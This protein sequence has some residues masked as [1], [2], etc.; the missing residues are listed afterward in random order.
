MGIIAPQPR[1][2]DKHS[3]RLESMPAIVALINA[4]EHHVAER[5]A[6]LQEQ[7]RFAV[8]LS[9]LWRL[10]HRRRLTTGRDND[11]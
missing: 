7:L 3:H 10:L 1:G 9:T 4:I 2:V 6:H 8:A 11:D 5:A